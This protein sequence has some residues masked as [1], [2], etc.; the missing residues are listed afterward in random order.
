MTVYVDDMRLPARIGRHDCTWSHL[1]A[2]TDEE[3]HAFAAKL[4]LKREWFQQGKRPW[5]GHY[6]VTAGKRRQAIRLGATPVTFREAGQIIRARAQAEKAAADGEQASVKQ[7]SAG[8]RRTCA[9]PHPHQDARLAA[10]RSVEVGDTGRCHDGH[11]VS[12]LPQD[13]SARLIAAGFTANSPELARI[14]QWNHSAQTRARI[15]SAA[16]DKEGE[17]T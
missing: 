1:F 6:D 7:Q 17:T 10:R 13:L 2:D 8:C 3:L 11:P 4:G 12:D 16:G 15:A 9:A 5:P 14:S